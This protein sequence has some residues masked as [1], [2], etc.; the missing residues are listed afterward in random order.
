MPGGG[1]GKNVPTDITFYGVAYGANKYIAV[2]LY[3]NRVA[4]SADGIT[5]SDAGV[6]GIPPAG[7]SSV[8][9][10][11]NKFVAVA[12]SADSDST[13]RAMYSTDGLSWTSATEAE[14]NSWASVT[15]GD[16]K[17]VAVAENGTNRV[18]YSAD[19]ESWS[20]ENVS[21]PDSTW[22]STTYGGGKFVA[23]ANNG[24]YAAMYSTDGITWTAASA[25]SGAWTGVAY[26]DGTY[27]AVQRS[28]TPHVM[29]ST[30]GGAN[31]KTDGVTGVDDAKWFAVTYGGGKFVATAWNGTEKQVMYSS[32]GIDW[33]STPTPSL[34][35]DWR[36]ITYG[37]G[38]FVA[39]ADD[40]GSD[41][42]PIMYSRDGVT[43]DG[44]LT[45]LT[46]TND[47]A[48]DS[49]DGTEMTT[50]D[51][52]FK[53]GDKVKG[54]GTITTAAIDAYVA[55]ETDCFSTKVYEGT[56]APQTIET[57]IDNTG[58]ALLW[59]KNKDIADTHVLYDTE[60]DTNYYLSSDS[61]NGNQD[62]KG[63]GL[64]EFIDNG[65][66]M[67]S[68]WSGSDNRK[69]TDIVAWNF[70]GA[71]GFMDVV[72]YDGD[73][74]ND[75][76][77]SHSLGAV[78]GMM[79]FKKTNDSGSWVVYHKETGANAF[80]YLHENYAATTNNSEMFNGTDPTDSDF[81]LGT[82][83]QVNN[84]DDNYVAYL[85]ADTP[86]T[87][88]CG[89][90]DG[91]DNDNNFVETG[92][93][94]G[95]VLI[96]N[97][98]EEA[99]WLI[100]DS[101]RATNSQYLW[102]NKP[103]QESGM[104]DNFEFNANG[105]TMGGSSVLNNRNGNEYIYV[106]IKEGAQAGQFPPS[107][108]AFST[109]LYT[110]TEKVQSIP[111]GIDN[112]SKSLVWI[113][114]RASFK[115]CLH[116]TEYT[117]R[118]ISNSTNAA[119]PSDTNIDFTNKGFTINQDIYI[120]ENVSGDKLVAWNFRAAPKFFD[121][122]TYEGDSD[123][124][125]A[126]HFQT[127]S[128]G[129]GS[130]PGMIII[131][132]LNDITTPG[133][134]KFYWNVYHKELGAGKYVR[135]DETI[136]ARTDTA[137]F[138]DTEPTST[139]FTVGRLVENNFLNQKY[140]AYLF[141]DTPGLI[142]CGSY[143][144]QLSGTDAVVDCGFKP[145][146]VMIKEVNQGGIDWVI[147]DSKRNTNIGNGLFP[148]DSK[149]EESI[150]TFIFT[151]SGFTASWG[152]GITNGG[153]SLKY[154]YVAI[155]ENAEADLALPTGVLTAD[156][157]KDSKS[158]TLTDVTG[159]WTEG[160]TAVN[161]E[162]VTE[163]APCGDDI[164]FTSS[165]PET[166]SGTVTT[167]GAAD[168]ELTNK[169]TNDTQTAS[170]TLKG[171]VEAEPGP[172]S[173]TLADD[174]NYSVRVQYSS[175]DPAAGPSEW[176]DV[177]NFKTCTKEEGWFGVKAAEDNRWFSVTYGGGKFVAVSSDGTHQV[178]HSDD[179]IDWEPALAANASQWESVTYGDGKFVAVASGGSGK[180]VMY[181]EDGGDTW[182]NDTNAPDDIAWWGVTYGGGKFVAVAAALDTNSVMHSPDGITWTM[183]AAAE[184]NY[185][186]SVTYG[187][188]KYVAVSDNGTNRVMHSPDGITWTS[189]SAVQAT[190]WMSVTYGDNKFV[191]VS[192]KGTDRVMHSPDAI[193][194]TGASAPESTS[195]REVTYGDGKFVAISDSGTNR[196]MYS[197]TE[198][199][200]DTW[201]EVAAPEDNAW[202]GYYSRKR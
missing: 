9:Y 129:L 43:W 102:P 167:W 144:G 59:L 12:R 139:E 175:A 110:G 76:K 195:W 53:Q 196:I 61:T 69:D 197:L 190:T 105:F 47:K 60:R 77:V 119:D 112:T 147:I 99:D 133:G 67:G 92:F 21:V 148:N 25:P 131:K 80:L 42:T 26:S 78:P 64:Q 113:K 200:L 152:D 46:F 122:V 138:N 87:I 141:A 36:V 176:S 128:H 153:T 191:A 41:K 81:T 34:Q 132:G 161:T 33:A 154:I 23:V 145:G 120:A 91:T 150:G 125:I 55:T 134:S 194:W 62:N 32:N 184:G 37:G 115:H 127:V 57:G 20:N 58:R 101:K 14:R 16:G 162:E 201:A 107:R 169:D 165:K 140:V 65:F 6:S 74:I 95:W 187:N 13:P 135:L 39:A 181:S 8:I 63:D 50:I 66:K 18:M 173:F 82:K 109:T 156:A 22:Y 159:I 142:K 98:T 97:T 130:A 121:V 158:M 86:G 49:A 202:R 149:K 188:N 171:N 1:L 183:A 28:N 27:V 151:D 75:K 198:S 104:G 7:F 19:G 31:W 100:F 88:K 186:R 52:A 79:I 174:T 24:T 117:G 146:W 40:T 193:T 30:D 96:K 143:L 126:G 111:T 185:W 38:K 172:T 157:D 155:A 180:R 116:S 2:G 177:N 103:D 48:Y 94:P 51:Q 10:A 44:D 29:Y 178:M 5:W 3:N 17:F 170:I 164:V 71:P 70:R 4:H 136:A 68:G 118:L 90:Y 108:K 163:N 54:K 89:A 45:K 192:T 182:K 85:F 189:A 168:W 93:K 160:L 35:H 123:S 166:T 137:A 84:L 83:T 199:D 106:A 114:S 179:G 11:D 124:L 72:T 73:G 15:Y 56:S